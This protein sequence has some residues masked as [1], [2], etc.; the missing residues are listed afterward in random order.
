MQLKKRLSNPALLDK[1][2]HFFSRIPDTRSAR[3]QMP[4]K[5][6]LMSALA[7]FQLKYPSL[8]SFT[9]EYHHTMANSASYQNLK[10][11][12]GIQKV[13]SDTQMRTTLDEI[14]I[15][16]LQKI[17]KYL[18][19]SVR[20]E[21]I[22]E[23]QF[24]FDNKILIAIDGTRYFSSNTIHCDQCCVQEHRDGRFTYYHQA[25]VAVIIHPDQ[26]TVFPIW[27]EP[28]I[29]QNG[30]SKND[31]ELNAAKRLIG[32]L[33]KYFPNAEFVVTQDGLFTN[34]PYIQLL[35][36]AGIEFIFTAKS[37]SLPGLLKAFDQE[38][39][40]GR[41]QTHRLENPNGSIHSYQWSAQMNLNAS[42][43]D[44][45]VNVLECEVT[46]SKGK[47]SQWCW[48]TNRS[49]NKTTVHPMA[50]AARA[51]WRIENETFN[52]LKN[53]GYHFEH[54]YGHGY[55]NLS[56]VL[57]ILMFVAF[58]ID[59]IVEFT[60]DVFQAALTSAKSRQKLWFKI[61]SRFDLILFT[62]WLQFYKSLIV[63]IQ[64]EYVAINDTS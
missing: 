55:K 22:I 62:D 53:H 61:L 57:M 43:P 56:V 14:E 45:K 38:K 36:E 51:R 9:D 1:T 13:P 29:R 8:L 64:P 18:I 26:K 44:C 63:W 24:K 42:H 17:L 41:V 6:A 33:T 5:D 47:Q 28:V 54:N 49:L 10:R 11:L 7:M 30:S 2:R 40:T 60:C 27:V 16:D 19:S 39:K 12:Y 59:Q 4:L 58:L 48:I 35:E 3:S 34:G 52:T 15:D 31:C 21:K 50:Q 25:V 32:H 37:G 20:R 23:R 46:D